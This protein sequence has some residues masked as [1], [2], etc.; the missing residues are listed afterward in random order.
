MFFQLSKYIASNSTLGV[1]N[2]HWCWQ[3]WNWSTVDV[4]FGHHGKGCLD[5]NFQSDVWRDISFHEVLRSVGEF[6]ASFDIVCFEMFWRFNLFQLLSF[7]LEQHCLSTFR[8]QCRLCF[9]P[10]NF[11]HL[12]PSKSFLYESLILFYFRKTELYT[13][14]DLHFGFFCLIGWHSRYHLHF[15]PRWISVFKSVIAEYVISLVCPDWNASLTTCCFELSVGE[16]RDNTWIVNW[17]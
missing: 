13:T 4:Q 15:R 2:I 3:F 12:F 9:W 16:G 8:F 10:F 1:Q 17:R 14:L 7:D 6:K 5:F 11:Q